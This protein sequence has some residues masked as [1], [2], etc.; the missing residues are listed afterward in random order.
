ME[1]RANHCA[2]SLGGGG[3]LGG[4]GLGL[5]GTGG[6]GEGGGGPAAEARNRKEG[7]VSAHVLCR[8]R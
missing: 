2:N 8:S 1:T 4:G 7:S 5:E 3:G 6:E